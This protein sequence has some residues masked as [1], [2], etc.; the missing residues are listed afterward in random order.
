MASA[1]DQPANN[2]RILWMGAALLIALGLWLGYP[3]IKEYLDERSDVEHYQ[4]DAELLEK[5][6][7]LQLTSSAGPTRD[8]PQWRGP[9]RDGIARE[10]GLLSSWPKDG[11]R[12]V[13]Q[14]STGPGYSSVAVA[15]GRAYTLVQDG[16]NEAVVCWNADNGAELWRVRNPGKFQ[17][18]ESGVGPHST[19][20]VHEGKVYTVGALGLFQCLD[21]GSGKVLWHHDLLKEFDAKLQE[22]G[23]SFSPLIEGDLVITLPGGPNGN[24]LA[25]F[26]RHDGKLAWKAFDDAAGYSSPVAATLAGTRQIVVLTAHHLMGLAPADG[27]LLWQF[28]WQIFKDCS[29][30]T[31]IVVGDYVY[32]SG[33]Y[34]KGCAL[35]AITAQAD[36]GFKAQRVYES[37]RMRNHFTTSVYHDGHVYGFDERMLVCM[38]FRTG[39]VRWKR[40]GF[41]KGNIMVADGRLVIFGENGILALAEPNPNDYKELSSFQLS[42]N[43]CWTPPALANGKL[44]VRDQE[45]LV[46]LDL[47]SP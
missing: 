9:H 40:R 43:R 46:C 47:K 8:W 11:P 35:I 25:A 12:R 22:Y 34:G 21:A 24:S 36:G 42:Q 7:A 17:N 41:E 15:D 29:I 4:S 3:K 26:H 28:P 16:D 37:N 10:N 38:E 44:Y 14:A 33:N 13:W 6:G 23:T 30:A 2:K 1:G 45:S 32:I 27:K 18:A 39:K 19:P 20:S 31:P 5:L